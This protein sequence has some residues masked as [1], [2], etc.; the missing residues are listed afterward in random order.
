MFDNLTGT[1]VE[2]KETETGNRFSHQAQFY[3][4]RLWLQ[5]EPK[6]P[7]RFENT[8]M[9]RFSTALLSYHPG[10]SFERFKELGG[11]S[12]ALRHMVRDQAVEVI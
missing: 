5:I 8:L 10:L 4:R 9:A 12:I 3:G 2:T 6:F 11:S 1:F 7:A